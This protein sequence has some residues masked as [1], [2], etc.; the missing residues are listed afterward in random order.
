M[1]HL[2]FRDAL[3]T[4]EQKIYPTT[5]VAAI[6][7][8][9]EPTRPF[10]D[11][12]GA[13]RLSRS[14]WANI[15]F[16]AIASIGGLICAF[17]FFNGGELLQ[18]AASWPREY[19]YPRPISAEQVA[20]AE[21]LKGFDRLGNGAETNSSNISDAKNPAAQTSTP[22]DFLQ[23]PA[24]AGGPANPPGGVSEPPPIITILPPP[25]PPPPISLR[26][27]IFNE[28]NTVSPGTDSTVLS[29]YQTVASTEPGTT[30]LQTAKPAA[31]STRRKV[32][33]AKPKEVGSTRAAAKSAAQSLQQTASQTMSTVRPA[34]QMM[35]SGGLGGMGSAG[36]I[37]SVGG[38]GSSAGSGA[39]SGVGSGAGAGAGGIGGVG[40]LGGAGLGGTVG[41]LGGVVG[42]HH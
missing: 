1:A 22:T 15:V 13:L 37:G 34:N 11:R 28:V 40:G 32:A 12:L 26:G 25:I 30:V 8:A 16:V 2:D 29:F 17:Y 41:G 38:S 7:L 6:P 19:L 35:S 24:L 36:L 3:S 31:K 14:S 9:P 39:G 10:A 23:G 4:P 18:A 5:A 20:L 27:Q 21:A 42:G 33:S